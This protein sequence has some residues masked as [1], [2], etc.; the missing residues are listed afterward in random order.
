[1]EYHNP[2]E[3]QSLR[4]KAEFP[5]AY[6]TVLLTWVAKSWEDGAQDNFSCAGVQTIFKYFF[7]WW[8]SAHSFIN[9]V[10]KNIIRLS[11]ALLLLQQ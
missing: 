4:I 2:A 7:I 3:T 1:M 8:S 10:V 6:T 5:T 9:I 11:T